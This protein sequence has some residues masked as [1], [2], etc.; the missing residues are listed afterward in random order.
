[1]VDKF[2]SIDKFMAYARKAAMS[3]RG[4]R[5]H[6][7]CATC[8]QMYDSHDLAQLAHHLTPKHPKWAP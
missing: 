5:R 8:S 6:L 3:P 7:T 4:A 1:M 2:Q